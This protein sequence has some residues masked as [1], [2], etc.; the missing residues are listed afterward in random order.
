MT[1]I[2][3]IV[4]PDGK[5]VVET[6][7]YYGTSCRDASKFLEQALGKQHAEA[8]KPEYYSTTNN[9]SEQAEGTP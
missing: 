3:I 2:T 7:G 5:A 1:S 4:K 6:S 9:M 8:L